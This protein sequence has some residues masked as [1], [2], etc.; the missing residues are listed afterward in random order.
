[1]TCISIGRRA[2]GSVLA[3][4][5]APSPKLRGGCGRRHRCGKTVTTAGFASFPSVKRG[6]V[7]RVVRRHAP[8]GARDAFTRGGTGRMPPLAV[9]IRAARK[10]SRTCPRTGRE[11]HAAVAG[12]GRRP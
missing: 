5:L 3:T 11:E 10:L 12:P 6:A 1:M 2:L 9:G 7:R 8:P 4:S